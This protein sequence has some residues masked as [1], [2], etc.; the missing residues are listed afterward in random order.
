MRELPLSQSQ[1]ALVSDEDFGRF[2]QFK[3]HAV[4]VKTTNSFYAE[5]WF[6]S[7]TKHREWMHRIVMGCAKRDGKQVDHVNG[8]TLDNRRENLR[9]VT[10]SQNQMNRKLQSASSSGM[11][12]VSFCRQTGLWKA[13]FVIQQ[14]EIWLGRFSTKDQAQAA[15]IAARSDRYGEYARMA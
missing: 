3:W 6:Y 10:H 1:V 15:V 9:F 11:R 14:K 13:R 8:D 4:W 7:P 5:A 12:G 2:S